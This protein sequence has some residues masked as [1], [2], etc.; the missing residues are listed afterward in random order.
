[1]KI[2]C[3]NCGAIVSTKFCGACGQSAN[4]R[5]LDWHF[6]W[7]DLQR[8]FSAQ[9][10]S[11]YHTIRGLFLR[12]GD[13]ILEY[14]TG[15]RVGHVGPL[16]MVLALSAINL[17]L[18]QTHKVMGT[19]ST[20][21]A[22]QWI[23]SHYAVAELLLVPLLA[24]ASYLGFHAARISLAWH[25]GLAGYLTAQHLCIRIAL[26]SMG[27][28]VHYTRL[29]LI[30]VAPQLIAAVLA[31]W[32]YLRVFRDLPLARRLGGLI[33]T[34]AIFLGGILLLA[35]CLDYWLPR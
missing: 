27:A 29:R 24:L 16:K 26:L 23:Y 8:L 11:F 5:E 33:L 30:F 21:G 9:D 4:T 28:L 13:F 12:P 34:Y 32:T 1:M 3:R 17:G 7:G 15:K 20:G 25:F 14:L 18:L 2:D 22:G 19:A 10:N 31:S 35:W 6:L